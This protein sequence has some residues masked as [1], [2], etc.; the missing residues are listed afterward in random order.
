MQDSGSFLSNKKF[1]GEE[2]YPYGISR[3][4][5]FNNEQS[6]LLQ[7]HGI[8]YQELHSGARAPINEEEQAFVIVCEGNR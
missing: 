4:G 6:T 1:Y 5:D 3:S 8:A 2:H 7:N